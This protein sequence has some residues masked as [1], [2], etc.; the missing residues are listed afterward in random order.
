MG[1]KYK[2]KSHPK[3]TAFLFACLK[4]DIIRASPGWGNRKSLIS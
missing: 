2:K 3:W 1:K 4:N